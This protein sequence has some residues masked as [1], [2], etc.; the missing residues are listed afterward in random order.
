MTGIVLADLV[1]RTDEEAF[2]LIDHSL[3]AREMV[4]AART[5]GTRNGS[6]R[7]D[8]VH[9][10]G[11][12]V[13]SKGDWRT[14]NDAVTGTVWNYYSSRDTVLKTLYRAVQVGQRPAGVS[15][16]KSKFPNIRDRNVSRTVTSHSGHYTGVELR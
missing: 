6:P 1:A 7:L 14:L 12:A 11:A 16:F 13:G 15:G 3:G 9:L 8:S 5:L 10:L 2:I 4:T